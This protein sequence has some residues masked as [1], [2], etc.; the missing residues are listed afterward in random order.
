MFGKNLVRKQVVDD[1]TQLWVQEVFYTLQGEGPFSGHPALFI[2]LAGCNLRCFWCDTEFES[3]EWS[4]TLDELLSR[5]EQLRPAACD[6]VV[7]T[8][9]EPLRQTITPLVNRLLAQG[10]RV[11]IET[12][13]T[14]W[15]ELP[16]HERLTIVCSPKTPHLN[17]RLERRITAYKYVLAAGEIETDGLPMRSTQVRDEEA[18][19]ARPLPGSTVYV[20]PRD[21]QDQKS[22]A[23][24][25]AACVEVSKRHGYRLTLQTHKLAGLP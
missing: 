21:D 2:R 24:N 9:G 5:V 16:E 20:M 22:N 4:P 14:L 7:I 25:L 12:A 11:Q 17:A 18:R 6:L 23:A 15:V 3:S 1:G 8:G 10:L 13:G 19:I